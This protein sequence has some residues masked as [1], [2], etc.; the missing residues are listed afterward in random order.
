MPPTGLSQSEQLR[1]KIRL[2]QPRLDEVA[3]RFW[4]HPRLREMF[5]DFLFLVH[6]MIRSSVPMMEAGA[7]AARRLGP[8]DP[9]GGPLARY[10]ARHAREEQHHDDW[11]LDDMEALDLDRREVLARTP[12][13]TVARLVGAFYYWIHHV[14]PVALMGYLAVLEGNPPNLAQLEDIRSRTGLPEE[15]FRTLVKHAHLDQRHRD[16]LNDEIDRLPLRPDLST[17]LTLAC[18]HTVDLVAV[19]F[20]EILAAHSL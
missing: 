16:D 6:S 1:T 4:T 20:E 12:S 17:L 7:A 8:G 3:R 14:H 15:G 13:T 19:G 18:F 10:F 11:L 9:A 5:P 2:A